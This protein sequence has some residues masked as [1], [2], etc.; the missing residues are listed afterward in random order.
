MVHQAGEGEGK[1]GKEKRE[2][3]RRR[4]GGRKDQLSLGG[5]VL[6]HLYL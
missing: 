4:N 2:E 6:G 5:K 1:V 3:R